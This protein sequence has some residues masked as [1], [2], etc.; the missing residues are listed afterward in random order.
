VRLQLPARSL[1]VRCAGVRARFSGRLQRLLKIS[2]NLGLLATGSCRLLHHQTQE[3]TPQPIPVAPAPQRQPQPEPPRSKPAKA[4]PL[5]PSEKG[6]GPNGIPLYL[7]RGYSPDD[8]QLLRSAFG[9]VAPQ[10]LYFSDSSDAAI[11]KYDVKL[12]L[13]RMCRVDTYRIGFL[14]MRRPQETWEQFEGRIQE[15][16]PKTRGASTPRH[17]YTSLHDLDPDAEAAFSALVEAGRHAGF[18]LSVVETYRTP[19]YEARLL[20]EGTGRTFTA[21]S[22]HSYGRAV[23]I[24]VDDGNLTRAS[25]RANWIRFRK[26]VTQQANGAFRLVGVPDNTWDW[27]HVELPAAEI[28]FHSVDD[29]LEFARRCL[30][31]SARAN[32]PSAERLGGAISDPCV[33]IPNLSFG[34]MARRATGK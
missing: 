15:P 5:S 28:G 12:K 2:A 19:E 21:T 17:F 7:A 4:P 18:K 32:A 9:I 31:D 10:N 6:I 33:V 16:A 20:A 11:L 14:S 8:R 29:A 27:L 22:L 24:R 25:T 1:D 23:D 34:T 26:F 13:C 3:P 30:T